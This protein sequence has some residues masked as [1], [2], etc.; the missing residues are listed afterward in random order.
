MILTSRKDGAFGRWP[1]AQRP[2]ERPLGPSPC[3]AR[4]GANGELEKMTSLQCHAG[5]SEGFLQVS[6]AGFPHG[7]IAC[8]LGKQAKLIKKSESLSEFGVGGWRVEL[9]YHPPIHMLKSSVGGLWKVGI[10]VV[11][12]TCRGTLQSLAHM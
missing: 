4:E 3:A 12:E 7:H 5:L 8:P 1:Q 9:K 2:P 11:K 10:W 6:H